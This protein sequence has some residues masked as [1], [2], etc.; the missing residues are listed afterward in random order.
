MI[1]TM[2]KKGMDIEKPADRL[3][4][5]LGLCAQRNLSVR[6]GL[7][8]GDM[9]LEQFTELQ[10]GKVVKNREVVP[11]A[12]REEFA[13]CVRDYA[14]RLLGEKAGEDAVRAISTGALLTADH[15]GALFCSQQI[16]GDLLF[17]GLLYSLGYQGNYIPVFSVPRWSWV[18]L[19]MPGGSVPPAAGRISFYTR[20]SDTCRTTRWFAAPR[21]LIRTG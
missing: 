19:P 20:Y 16:Q 15:H 14:G 4:S 8:Y 7:M 18:I 12:A 21:R 6:T 9:T 5:F 10:A 11:V 2:K 17:S 13:V 3:E 1:M